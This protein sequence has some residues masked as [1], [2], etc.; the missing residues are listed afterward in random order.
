[1]EN[2]TIQK[3]I[4]ATIDSGVANSFSFILSDRKFIIEFKDKYAAKKK[5]TPLVIFI[6]NQRGII[7]PVCKIVI[8]AIT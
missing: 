1:M 2:A 4:A 6:E 5:H 8:I 7:L 3:Q